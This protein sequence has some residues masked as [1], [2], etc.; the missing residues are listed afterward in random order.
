MGLRFKPGRTGGIVCKLEP[1]QIC[2]LSKTTELLQPP[3]VK[4]GCVSSTVLTDMDQ[5]KWPISDVICILGHWIQSDAGV[6]HDRN[7]T[8]KGYV[9]CFLE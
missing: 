2:L 1:S 8:K 6:R 9:G 7:L 3:W 5:V 4:G